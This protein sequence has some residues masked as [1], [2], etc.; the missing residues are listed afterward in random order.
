MGTARD[1]VAANVLVVQENAVA[2][3]RALDELL[4]MA[5]K[6]S[7][8]RE[9]AGYTLEALAELCTTSLLPDRPLVAFAHRP[10]AAAKPSKDNDRR[11]LLWWAEDCIKRR[12]GR[13]L[14]SVVASC[15]APN[16][17][18]L[19]ASAGTC[20]LL[21]FVQQVHLFGQALCIR[22]RFGMVFCLQ[23]VDPDEKNTFTLY[24]SL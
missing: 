22:L 5:G 1:K 19:S 7:G 2:N 8:A 17:I 24:P 18:V 16:S 4:N 10:V 12:C 14:G 3:M 11:L 21:V 9:I 6:S 23:F 13:L 20:P 15:V